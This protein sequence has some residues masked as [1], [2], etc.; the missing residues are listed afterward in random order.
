M[1]E[2]KQKRILFAPQLV[3]ASSSP[4]PANRVISI[5]LDDDED[6]NWTW[7]LLSDGTKYVN[8]YTV[9]KKIV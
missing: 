9:I 6:V 2:N 5:E 8:G 7:T 3:L 4:I 1:T